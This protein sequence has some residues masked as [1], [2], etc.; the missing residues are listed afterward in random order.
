M[1]ARYV[2]QLVSGDD[3]DQ[4]FIKSDFVV[5]CLPLSPN[6]A[7]IISEKELRLMQPNAYLINVSRGKVVEEDIL[8]TALKEKWI[9][10]AG[11]DVFSTEPL[12]VESP[13]W[14][15]P[16]VIYSAHSSGRLD[17]R[18]DQAVELFIM[19]LKRYIGGRRL[20]NIVDKKAG[21]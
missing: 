8:I 4:I 12:P 21:F 1:R 15:L 20:L 2:D 14:D 18:D 9:A 3:I 10:G 19:N 13:L 7:G 16:N 11:L 17:N 6:T 5:S